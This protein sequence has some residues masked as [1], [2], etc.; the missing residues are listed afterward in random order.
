MGCGFASM[1]GLTGPRCVTCSLPSSGVDAAGP[2][3]VNLFGVELLC[4]RM[5]RFRSS[6]CTQCESEPV[7]C[8]YI[9]SG[10]Q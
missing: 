1:A 3:N 9:I 6:E 4:A 5:L 2:R 8:S 10:S 7:S